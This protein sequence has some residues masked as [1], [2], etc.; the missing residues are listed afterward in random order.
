M[1]AV[2]MGEIVLSHDPNVGGQV[3]TIIVKLASHE[4]A[5]LHGFTM[6][7]RVALDAPKL[8]GDYPGPWEPRPLGERTPE[9]TTPD[10]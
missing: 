10:L 2:R 1:R 9:G 5:G 3:P 7:G 4:S 6:G 8:R